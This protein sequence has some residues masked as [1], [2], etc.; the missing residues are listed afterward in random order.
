MLLLYFIDKLFN[1]SVQ[2]RDFLEEKCKIIQNLYHLFVISYSIYAFFTSDQEI[3]NAIQYIKWH[4]IIDLL[5]CSRRMILHHFIIF[6]IST[7]LLNLPK[8][9]YENTI[10]ER[11]VF[12]STEIS[13]IFM[14]LRNIIPKRNNLLYERF[15]YIN[16]FLFIGLFFYTRIF[17]YSYFLIYNNNLYEKIDTLY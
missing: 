16:D 13:S 1:L 5:F 4:C 3:V 8:I 10:E 2:K 14:I 17:R 11:A 15:L 6:I 9:F 12:L 7:N